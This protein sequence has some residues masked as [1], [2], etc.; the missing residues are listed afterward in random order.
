MRGS[1]KTSR[2]F[3]RRCA[4]LT[5]GALLALSTAG[6]TGVTAGEH[7]S[8]TDPAAGIAA[9]GSLPSTQTVSCFGCNLGIFDDLAMTSNRGTMEVGTPKD[10]YIGIQ[11]GS[12]FSALTGIELSVAGIRSDADGILVIAL[13][14]VEPAALILGSLPAPADTSS[15]SVGL[16]GI[17]MV[18]STCLS[19]NR[20]LSKLTLLSFIPI[21]NKII[22]VKRKYPTSNPVQWHTPILTLCDNPVFT[23]VRL[24]GGCYGINVPPGPLPCDVVVSVES[25]TWSQLKA[26]YE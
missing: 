11:Y 19:N 3:L 23:A 14:P 24:T 22:T 15:T 9:S 10:L 12:G 4:L 7:S 1:T 2:L 6:V 21:S 17:N 8:R 18:W 26:L 16:G 5:S 25:K 20:A 13:D